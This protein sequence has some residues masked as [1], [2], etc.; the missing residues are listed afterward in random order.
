MK[1]PSLLSSHGERQIPGQPGDM[2]RVF[3]NG[4]ESLSLES[5]LKIS[6][7]GKANLL[8]VEYT[9]NFWNWT[10]LSWMSNITAVF[11]KA[12]W[13]TCGNPVAVRSLDPVGGHV[14][15]FWAEEVKTMRETKLRNML[16]LER[17]DTYS[18][19]NELFR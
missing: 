16:L 13:S 14:S 11:C 9:D 5:S 4:K 15:H 7:S 17:W 8:I 3:Y 18:P 10:V 6:Y 2:G 12:E 1:F 19:F